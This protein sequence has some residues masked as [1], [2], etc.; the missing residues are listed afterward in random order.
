MC[1]RVHVCVCVCVRDFP[2]LTFDTQKPDTQTHKHFLAQ[3]VVHASTHKHTNMYT[4]TLTCIHQCRT[5]THSACR[6]TRVICVIHTC[7]TTH[8]HAGTYAPANTHIYIPKWI[9]CT[10]VRLFQLI[11]LDSEFTCIGDL[12]HSNLW[13]DSYV[14]GIYPT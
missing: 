12:T 10:H 3:S 2:V 8:S 14:C 11:T 5:C 7:D 6:I 1:V 13:H 4:N 9:Q